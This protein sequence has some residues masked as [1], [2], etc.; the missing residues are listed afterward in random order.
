VGTR[1]AQGEQFSG[2]LVGLFM[3]RMETATKAGFH[4]MNQA[5]KARAESQYRSHPID[6]CPPAADL[7]VSEPTAPNIE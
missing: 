2:I 5:L 4:A 3:S 7:R 1:F 6:A